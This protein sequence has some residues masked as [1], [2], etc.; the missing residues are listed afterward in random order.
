MKRAALFALA[1]LLFSLPAP[2]WALSKTADPFRPVKER[3]IKDGFPQKSV[4]IYFQN[5]LQSFAVKGVSGYFMHNEAKLNYGR[6]LK[7]ERLSK[8]RAYL[9]THAPIDRKSVV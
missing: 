1:A 5:G 7:K 4:D 8:D 2:G 3:L 9:K 6:F